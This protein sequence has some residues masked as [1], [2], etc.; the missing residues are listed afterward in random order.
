[1]MENSNGVALVIDASGAPDAAIMAGRSSD[2]AVIATN[3]GGK[4]IDGDEVVGLLNV[5]RRRA[6]ERAEVLGECRTVEQIHRTAIPATKADNFSAAL[7]ASL[8]HDLKTLL[9]SIVGA[10]EALRD[11]HGA[12]DEYTK[13]ELLSAILDESLRLNRF[14]TNL[15]NITRLHGRAL[16]PNMAKHDLAEIVHASLKSAAKLL[17][18]HRIDVG[19]SPDLPML[20]VDAALLEQALTNLLDNAAKYSPEGAAIGIK[21]YRDRNAILLL[22]MDEGKGIS[23]CDLEKVFERFYRSK[24][25]D[26]APPGTGLGLTISRAFIEAMGGSI[27]AT[28]R[29][30]TRGAQ[31]AIRFDATHALS[32]S[33]P[34]HGDGARHPRAVENN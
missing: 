23:S 20:E 24:S 27:I 15:F 8:S 10:A 1:M 22:V 28:N 34:I 5:S 7:L 2:G 14:V 32:P 31:F 19:I 13:A 6:V 11:Y 30:D 29:T 18:R 21:V 12:M 17:I 26:R 33:G 25:A 4:P 16:V 9:T 3:F